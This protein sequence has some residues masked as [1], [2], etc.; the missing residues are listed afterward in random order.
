MIIKRYE[1]ED[2]FSFYS[3]NVK[4]EFSNPSIQAHD[5]YGY[6]RD[7]KW[8]LYYYYTVTVWVKEKKYWKKLFTLYP[9]DF[10]E[11]L[12]FKN[13]LKYFID[14]VKL[15]EY[16]KIYHKNGTWYNYNLDTGNLV[17]DMYSVQHSFFDS[18]G[19]KKQENYT[20]TVGKP[21]D[22]YASNSISV[23]INYLSKQDLI[24]IYNCVSDFV[25][26]S[27]CKTNELIIERNR[28]SLASWKY[29]NGK[30]YE[31]DKDGVSV[32]SVFVS[33][34]VIDDAIILQ[35]DLNSKDFISY[36]ITNFTIDEIKEDAIVLSS[37]CEDKNGD[38][39]KI[40]SSMEIKLS[41]LLSLFEDMSKERLNFNEDEILEDF[42]GILSDVEKKE[43]V[44]KSVDFLFEKWKSAMIDRTW[45]CRDEHNLPK[46]VKNTGN[47]ENVYASVKVIIERLQNIL[48]VELALK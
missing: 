40:E 3:D 36:R 15:E 2:K 34:D 24:E 23:G 26:Y 8:I 21:F 41:C 20:I 35:G 31:M 30:L 9:Y 17:E 46:R 45:M 6:C 32:K 4:V 12:S 13:I 10:P 33:G 22:Y 25:E 7:E 28:E 39:R 29:E 27:I 11:I 47:H 44:D 1:K 19:E 16:Q 14:G 5:D 37:G 42:K 43:F 18:Q 48:T 38:Y